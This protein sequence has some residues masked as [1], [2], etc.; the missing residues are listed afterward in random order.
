MV[1]LLTD[2]VYPESTH[3]IYIL[4][5]MLVFQEIEVL[6]VNLFASYNIVYNSHATIMKSVIS[7]LPFYIVG[8]TLINAY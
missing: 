8:Q 4:I 3:K 1:R 6:Q 7:T 2:G 5:Y